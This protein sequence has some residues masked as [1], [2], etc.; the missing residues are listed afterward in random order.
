MNVARLFKNARFAFETALT[1]IWLNGCTLFGIWAVMVLGCTVI[2]GVN[3]LP[4]ILTATEAPLSAHFWMLEQI[5]SWMNCAAW[6]TVALFALSGVACLV[7]AASAVTLFVCSLIL[8][9]ARA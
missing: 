1:M 6:P 8:S 2:W 9:R 3:L 4:Y 5:T 7:T